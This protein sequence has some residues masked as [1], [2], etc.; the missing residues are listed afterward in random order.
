MY[1]ASAEEHRW[2]QRGLLPDAR[3]QPVADDSEGRIHP[4]DVIER[5][6]DRTRRHAETIVAEP[7]DVAD[8]YDHLGQLVSVRVDLDAVELPA[9][10]T[11][12][13]ARSRPIWRRTRGRISYSSWPARQGVGD[14]PAAP[15]PT[16]AVVIGRVQL[17]S[18]EY[19]GE[20]TPWPH[21][22]ASTRPEARLPQRRPIP[23]GLCILGGGEAL[24]RIGC[25]RSSENI[26]R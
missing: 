15:A 24:L 4:T 18:A 20:A 8:P 3:R 6:Q 1:F 22:A 12:P 14:R 7:L 16:V 19:A 10:R 21:H 9:T 11:A 17:A 26:L 2:V 13:C 5:L 25:Y 23:R